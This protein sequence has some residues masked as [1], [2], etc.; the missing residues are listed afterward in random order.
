VT[1]FDP[2]LYRGTAGDYDRFR[3][4]YP[5]AM[6]DGLLDATAPSGHGRLLDLACGTGQIT[7][8]LAERFTEVWAVDQEP[9][10]IELVRAKAEAIP[11]THVRAFTVRAEEL[12]A[13]AGAFELVAI[14]NAFHRLH[15]EAVAASAL[16]W[17]EPNGWI[18]LLWSTG[19]WTGEADWQITLAAAL[20][21]WR[22]EAG[23]QAR[24]PAGWDQPRK[25]WPDREVLASVGFRDVRSARFPTVHEWS[26]EQL[27]GLVYSTS[28]LS[29]AALGDKADA[30]E[31]D[32]R[33]ELGD[34]DLLRE[35]IDFN[36]EIARRPA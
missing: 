34:H 26:I 29:R 5:E 31:R 7:F 16:R 2:D 35:T 12:V 30:F 25:Q 3:V 32:I 28:F 15:R 11:D 10:M 22:I 14:G 8:A 6:I 27:I 21:R 24:I 18:A 1:E 17:L 4:A 9:D 20:D 33:R 36:Y 23:A 19:P 13:P